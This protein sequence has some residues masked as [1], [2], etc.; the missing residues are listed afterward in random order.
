[1]TPHQL[2]TVTSSV[3]HHVVIQHVCDRD[4]RPFPIVARF[5]NESSF[6]TFHMNMIESDLDENEAVG[7]RHSQMNRR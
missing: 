2:F 7:E 6:K 1:M 4:M 3:L 5:Q